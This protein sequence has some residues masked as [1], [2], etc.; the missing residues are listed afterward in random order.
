M[1]RWTDDEDDEEASDTDGEDKETENGGID[2]VARRFTRGADEMISRAEARGNDEE[3]D[4]GWQCAVCTLQND[5]SA[6]ACA[7]CY[8]PRDDDESG[9]GQSWGDLPS[10]TLPT[11][12]SEAGWKCEACTLN[13][14]P[15]AKSCA[16]CGGKRP[17]IKGSADSEPEPVALPSFSPTTALSSVSAPP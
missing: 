6:K 14:K 16:A 17:P 4:E 8:T 12:A 10:A 7:A 2:A 15:E 5:E 1:G 3:G 11:T 9:E 13:N